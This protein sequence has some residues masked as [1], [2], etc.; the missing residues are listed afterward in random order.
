MNI[1]PEEVIARLE[2]FLADCI[3]VTK[4]TYEANR[5]EMNSDLALHYR[6]EL[7]AYEIVERQLERL[8]NKPFG[9]FMR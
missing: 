2:K 5:R 1:G 7:E 4:Q 6:G 8:K 3:A 9:K